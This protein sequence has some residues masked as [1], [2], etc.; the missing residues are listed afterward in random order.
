DLEHQQ[1]V[2][3]WV[4]LGGAANN[5]APGLVSSNIGADTDVINGKGS[6]SLKFDEAVRLGE[7]SIVLKKVGEGDSDTMVQTFSRSESTGISVT[8]NSL[9]LDPTMDL[10]A[11]EYYLE[12]EGDAIT[13]LSDVAAAL[14]AM[15]FTVAPPEAHKL[16]ITEVTSKHDSDIDY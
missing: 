1:F 2:D 15:S 6:L 7:G 3:N 12:F 9:T 13:D 4:V 14:P 11:G 16:L 8:Y 10:E 5:M